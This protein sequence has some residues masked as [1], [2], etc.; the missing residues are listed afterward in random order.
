MPHLKNWAGNYTYSTANVFYPES[1]EES[2]ELVRKF[3]RI[4]VLGSRH[5][6]NAIADSANAFLSTDKLN[7]IVLLDRDHEA[8]TIEPGVRYG[9]LCQYLND[10]GYAIHNMA[11]LAS[12]SIAGA[13]AT[14]T[15]GSGDRNGNL[16]TAVS[17]IE[18]INADG[19]IV[20]YSREKNSSS[21]D[22]AVAHLGALGMV[23]R[24]TLDIQ[25][26][27]EMKQYVYEDLPFSQLPDNYDA[28][29]SAAYSV[30]LF[31]NWQRPIV[32]QIWFK[33]RDP[34]DFDIERLGAAPADG[35]RHP[36]AGLP[37][38]NC[39]EQM[40]IPGPWCDRM[41]HFK[42]GFTPSH[43]EE[44]QSEF[45]VPRRHAVDALQAVQELSDS[46]APLLF[47]SEVRTIAADNLWMS[48]CYG[49]HCV[50]IHFTWKPMW[51]EVKELLPAIEKKLTPFEARPH[52]G[53]LFTMPAE[54]VQA[55]YERLP[56]FRKLVEELD[57][58]GK[59]RNRFLE[60]YT[61]S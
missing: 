40:G 39:T 12:I 2:Q 3:D 45:F 23:T 19:E 15:H 13:V 8:V 5:S 18:L 47:V 30:S 35:P 42:M 50:G 20:E 52:W 31:T 43:G 4:K 56:D 46:I 22:G 41:P 33:C 21:F 55:R 14:A 54:Q 10:H 9:P 51:T 1:I 36:L 59:F 60:T 48:P 11:S 27:F 17:A 32:D 28:I 7:R 49:Q 37:V 38:E 6:F 34:L 26:A 57:P 44:L 61:G 24:L 53:K 16:S 58:A 29:T 25:P